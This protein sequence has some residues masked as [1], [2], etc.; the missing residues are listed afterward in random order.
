MVTLV[1]KKKAQVSPF[2][3]PLKAIAQMFNNPVQKI[4]P[5]GEHETKNTMSYTQK[6]VLAGIART[7]C[8]QLSLT[9]DRLD[10]GIKDLARRQREHRGDE[11]SEVALNRA[12]DWVEQLEL[13]EATLS[14][15]LTETKSLYELWTGEQ[16]VEPEPKNLP[17]KI[18]SSEAM[19]RAARYTKLTESLPHTNG[20]ETQD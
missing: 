14:D 8:Y 13:Q 9:K 19:A 18:V 11:I 17:R 5:N 10:Q 4:G 6:M 2:N 20:V 3:A 15:F 16:F 12:C 1:S 7:L